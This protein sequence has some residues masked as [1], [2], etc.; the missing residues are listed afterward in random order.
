MSIPHLNWYLK[1]CTEH[2]ENGVIH[3][4]DVRY[5]AVAPMIGAMRLA[6]QT[7]RGPSYRRRP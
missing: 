7:G 4:W 2:S 6:D 5:I 3:F 1:W